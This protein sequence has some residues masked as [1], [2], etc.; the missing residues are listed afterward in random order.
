MMDAVLLARFQFALTSIYHWLFVPF[1]LGMTVLVAILEVTYVMTKNEVYK[2]MAKFWGKLFLINFAMGVVTGIVQEF[3]FGMNW[4]EYSRFMG[5]IFGA[6]LALEALTAFFLES[7][8]MGAWIFGW[9]KM[10]PRLHALTAVLV[11]IGTNLSAFWILVANSF[12]QNPVGFV[13]RNG[14][15]EME[16]F[17]AILSNG[18]VVGQFAHIFFGGLLMAAVIIAAFSAWHLLRNS[19]TEFYGKSIRFGL[20]AALI[21]GLLVAGAGHHQGQYVSKVQPMKTAS[22]EALW[23]TQDPAPFSLFASIDEQNKKN[24]FEISVPGALSFVVHNSFTGEVKG[25]N[26]LQKEAELKYGPGDYVPHVTSM[27]WTFRVMIAAGML[28]LL[29]S[30]V[31]YFMAAKGTLSSSPFVLKA[32]FWMLPLPYIAHSTGWYVAEMGRQPW[33]VYGL[34]KTADGASLV[35]TAGE[36]WTTIIGFTAIYALAAV[37]AI[38]LAIKH[39]KAGPDGN[40]SHD[41]VE[42]EQEGATLWK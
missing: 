42:V 1:T 33:L 36:I 15:A 28:M 10:S 22:F 17:S 26:D 32:I 37:A 6:P 27:F 21:S 14:R 5:D 2:K 40:P 29:I 16:S 4:S 23:E 9:D 12:M 41:V 19:H 31:G 39:I 13:I 8:F 38:Y 3:H 25:I 35:V 7:T 34:Q 30:A 11:A 18:Y 24:N 20:A